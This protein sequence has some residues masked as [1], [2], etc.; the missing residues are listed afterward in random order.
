MFIDTDGKP[1]DIDGVNVTLALALGSPES[2]ELWNP[3][4]SVMLGGTKGGGVKVIELLAEIV[5]MPEGDD[6]ADTEDVAIAV[7]FEGFL[8]SPEEGETRDEVLLDDVVDSPDELEADDAAE[9]LLLA[10]MVASPEGAEL[11]GNLMDELFNGT[12]GKLEEAEEL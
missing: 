1:D 4:R 11:V 10:D 5:G 7:L 9:E 12:V 8:G 2:V 6:V 3:D